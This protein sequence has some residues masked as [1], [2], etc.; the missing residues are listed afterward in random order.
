MLWQSL[1]YQLISAVT[2][3]ALPVGLGYAQAITEAMLALNPLA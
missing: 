2:V 3:S 1:I